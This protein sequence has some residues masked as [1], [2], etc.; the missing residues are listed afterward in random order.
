VKTVGGKF[1]GALAEQLVKHVFTLSLVEAN[2]A[3]T[4]VHRGYI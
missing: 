3:K 2:L 4:S 1:A